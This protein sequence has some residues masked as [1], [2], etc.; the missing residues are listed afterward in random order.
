LNPEIEGT[1][2]NRWSASWLENAKAESKQIERR[3]N[4]VKSSGQEK[5]IRQYTDLL[6]TD[7]TRKKPFG[8]KETLKTLLMRTRMIIINN[9]QLRK[10]MNEEQQRLEDILRWVEEDE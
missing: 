3:K 7:L 10:D 2:I 9:D 1:I 4:I 5:A 8:V 6:S